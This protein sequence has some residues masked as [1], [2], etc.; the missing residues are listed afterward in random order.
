MFFLLLWIFGILPVIK[1]VF[2]LW[3]KEEAYFELMK[4]NLS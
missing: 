1:V 4:I 3:K 2:C